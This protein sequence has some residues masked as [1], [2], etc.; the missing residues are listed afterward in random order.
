MRALLLFLATLLAGLSPA[1]GLAHDGE[2]HPAASA[3]GGA[4]SVIAERHSWSPVCPPGSGHL[5]T[6]GNLSLCDG[7]TKPAALPRRITSIP[8][9]IQVAA[10]VSQPSASF[11]PSPQFPPSLPR[12]PPLA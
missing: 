6:C 5:C 1:A 9:R 7:A 10:P 2:H 8:H 11:Q 12:A 4:N 3:H